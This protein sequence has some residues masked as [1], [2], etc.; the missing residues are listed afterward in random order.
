MKEAED[1]KA[2]IHELSEALERLG[3]KWVV[4][5][6]NELTIQGRQVQIS[7]LSDGEETR[8]RSR[9][10]AAREL[11]LKVGLK[12]G[13]FR[14]SDL[15]TVDYTPSEVLKTLADAAELIVITTA[16]VN[17]SVANFTFRHELTGARFEQ[18]GFA[19]AQPSDRVNREVPSAQLDN[20]VDPSEEIIK[21]LLKRVV[22][23]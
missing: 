8:L 23:K 20:A 7:S 5:Q 2:Q 19:D 22:S 10:T 9:L 4:D 6:L 3:C 16:R 14:P 1:V 12:V 11:G 15:V 21:S 17:R 18:P 13:P